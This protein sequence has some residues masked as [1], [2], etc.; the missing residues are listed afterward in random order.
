M[1]KKTKDTKPFAG[2]P[3][4]RTSKGIS[5]AACRPTDKTEGKVVLTADVASF[6]R[7]CGYLR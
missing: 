2:H 1:K 7:Y 5:G 6:W 3:G 4:V